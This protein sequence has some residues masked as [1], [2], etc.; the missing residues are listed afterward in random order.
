MKRKEERRLILVLGPT[1]VGKSLFAATFKNSFLRGFDFLALD[2]GLRRGTSFA[3]E[4][5]LSEKDIVLLERAKGNGY[6]IDAY[7]LF[8]AKP[9]LRLRDRY[10]RLLEEKKAVEFVGSDSFAKSL[11]KAFPLLDLLFLA[12]NQKEIEFVSA[13]EPSEMEKA[14]FASEVEHL[15]DGLASN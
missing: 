1:A 11:L 15:L 10:S 4:S 7:A 5:T 6:Q 14:D 9:L 8:A 12:T 2:E 3:A 13:Y